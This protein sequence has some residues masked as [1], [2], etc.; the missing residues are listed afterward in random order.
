M[1]ATLFRNA[2]LGI[3]VFAYLVAWSSPLR[4][5][6]RQINS[7]LVVGNSLTYHAPVPSLNWPGNWGMAATSESTDYVHRLLN[8]IAAQQG[9]IPTL[10]IH[11]SGG[12]T[13]AGK[14]AQREILEG[15]HA[16]LIIVQMGENDSQATVAGFQEPY[17]ELIEILT[18]AN[19]G[20]E[21]VCTGVW[22]SMSKTPFIRAV[23]TK[24]GLPFADVTSV[25]QD[26][27]NSGSSTGLWT[28]AGVG[29]HPSDSGME[30]Y[31][32]VIWNAFDFTV[33]NVNPEPTGPVYPAANSTNFPSGVYTDSNATPLP[34]RY[35]KPVGFNPADTTTR[36]PLVLYLHGSGE[37]GTDNAKQL[38]TNANYSMIFLS[39]AGPNNQALHPCFWLAPQCYDGW[40]NPAYVADQVQGLIDQFMTQFPIDPDR[41]YI[42]GLSAGASGVT[43]Q[44]ANFPGRWAAAHASAGW[45]N[46]NEAGYKHVPFW[47]F[48][49]ADDTTVPVAGSD[50]LAAGLRAAGGNPI[51][52]RYNTGG[53]GTAWGRAYSALTPLVPWMMSQRRGQPVSKAAGPTID[54]LTPTT[55]VDHA[56][57]AGSL[58]LGGTASA[59]SLNTLS[60][61]KGATTGTMS[62]S[63]AWTTQTIALS[64][65]TNRVQVFAKGVAYAYIGNGSTTFSDTI[66]VISVLPTSYAAWQAGLGWAGADS[67]PDG[68]PDAD[69]CSNLAE[70]AWGTSPLS[71]A[72]TGRPRLVLSGSLKSLDFS[73]QVRNADLGYRVQF[74]TDLVNWSDLPM[75]R[76]GPA[77]AL[78][79]WQ[80]STSPEAS[81]NKGFFKLLIQQIP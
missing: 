72:Q 17:D 31:A 68:D 67:S 27:A 14:L 11:A 37:R 28:D 40:Q 12:G 69:G 77:G 66:D 57:A 3:L 32:N 1:P 47:I 42:T 5:A 30:G 62:G 13:L 18:T 25:W 44:L 29:W 24:Y 20:S 65:G 54:I 61:K 74:S 81:E 2:G 75:F 59:P 51:Y 48:H 41:I 55:S 43:Y 58:V 10:Q 73:K 39:S 6:T 46:G 60:W 63:T 7:V 52:T 49:T 71:G 53:H 36:Y 4:A 80:A 38:N 33:P 45:G 23:C 8:R 35:F 22:K 70:Y 76:I 56:L 21:F 19:P 34:Y 64:T 79:V 50:N 16:D 15:L 9:V 26:P 78:E